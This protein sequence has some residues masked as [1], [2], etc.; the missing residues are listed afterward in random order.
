MS[1]LDLDECLIDLA[2]QVDLVFS[3]LVDVKEFPEDVDV[4][5]SRAR[6]ATRRTCAGSARSG[7]N[8]RTLVSFGD[9]AVTGNV[10]ALRNPLGPAAAA[11]AG[12]PRERDAQPQIPTE[13]VP[14]LL[15]TVVPVH[16]VVP[17]DVFLPGCPPSADLIREALLEPARG[18]HP[19][20][21]GPRPV[22]EVTEAV[23]QEIVIDPVTRIEGH[24]K[25]TI[26]L[27]DAGRGG[28]RPV[29]RHG[30]PRLRE[31]LRGP[32]VPRD[33]GDHGA[34]LRDLPGQPPDGL[35]EGRRRDPGGA[36]RLR[37]PRSCAGS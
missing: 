21:R 13:V 14:A 36:S 30:V 6:V 10:P 12:L 16:A 23:A 4:A 1:F 7:A 26:Q 27:D 33:A 17:V 20:P 34:D 35:G 9:C 2:E 29:P 32:A 5:W 8:D 15:P 19:R 31:V 37:P 3:P 28:R 11:P 24:A 25:I 22:R 18:A